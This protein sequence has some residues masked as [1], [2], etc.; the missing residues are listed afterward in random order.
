MNS[1]SWFLYLTDVLGNVSTAITVI[2]IFII[3]GILMVVLARGISEGAAFSDVKNFWVIVRR[4]ALVIVGMLGV[5]IFI[6]EKNTMYAIAVSQVGEQIAQTEA[7][8]GITNDG[9]LALRSWIK[10]QL[11]TEKAK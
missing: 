8:K 10:K 11:D 1:L 4:W 9:L 7:V 5:A 2:N 3:T 6:P